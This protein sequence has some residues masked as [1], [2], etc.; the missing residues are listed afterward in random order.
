VESKLKRLSENDKYETLENIQYVS[1]TII[2]RL[3]SSFDSI[4][5]VSKS[6]E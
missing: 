3:Y 1:E 5:E 2:K 6:V 4:E